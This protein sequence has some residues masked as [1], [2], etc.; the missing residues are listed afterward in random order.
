MPRAIWKGAVTFGL[1]NI[2]VAL[3]PVI[4][5]DVVD[6]DLLDK[7]TMD[8]IGYK[9]INKRT[10]KEVAKENVVKGVKQAN[11]SY[12]V[13]TD[14]EI[15][16]AYPRTTQT[17]EIEA[18]VKA[19]EIPFT[20]LDRPYFLEAVEKAEKV[21]ALLCQAMDQSGV[22]GIGRIIMHNK[23]HLAAVIPFEQTLMLDTLRWPTALRSL[24]SLERPSAAKRGADISATEL[25][26]A[27]ELIR[28]M[29]QKWRPNDYADTFTQA[30]HAL[31]AKKVKA[32]KSREVE[33]FEEAPTNLSNS[34]VIDLTALLQNSLR[35]PSGERA[36]TPA[37]ATR[38]RAGVK[39]L[40]R[41]RA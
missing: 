9:R 11:N 1:V 40:A 3:Y 2:P 32:G 34:N 38:S 25:K 13:L 28:G 30:I 18:F 36:K 41:K 19:S 39:K 33:P 24:E 20:Y 22:I 17:I 6:F 15:R 16:Q 23:E 37:A 35:R 26:M 4:R 8:P 10:G 5:E 27:Q 21:Y 7:K 12:V 29:S 31:I 14:E